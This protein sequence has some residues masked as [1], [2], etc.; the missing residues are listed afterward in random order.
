MTDASL[1]QLQQTMRRLSDDARE[2]GMVGLAM[3]YAAQAVRLGFERTKA[4]IDAARLQ[5]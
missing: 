3:A 5:K 1:S 4:L 2:R